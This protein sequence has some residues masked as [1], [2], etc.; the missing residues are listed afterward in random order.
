MVGCAPRMS[1]PH[2]IV[3]LSSQRWD[4]TMWTN[5]QHIMSRLARDHVVLHVDHGLNALPGYVWNQA[6][7]HVSSLAHPVRLLT[8]GVVKRG[9][10]LFTASSFAPLPVQWLAPDNAVRDFASYE[11]KVRRVARFMRRNAWPD[12]IVWVYHP[13]F[14]DALD[15]LPRKLL[16]YDCVDN[17]ASF[18]E[19]QPVAGW[20]NAREERLCRNADLVIT[21]SAPLYEEKRAYNPDHT[22]LVH[23]VGDAEHFAKSRSASTELP[24]DMVGL[25]HPRIGFV[26][27]VSD[28]KLDLEWLQHLA[29]ARP[30][31]QLILIGPVGLSDEST[32]V[33]A[34]R[35]M[36]NVHL[37]GHRAYADLPAYLRA[38][39]V[40]VIPYRI[41]RYTEGV[42]PIKF[43]ELLATGK[44]VV[45]SRL[46]ALA[47]FYDAVRVADDAPGF[48]TA[49]EAALES[50]DEGLDRRLALADQHSWPMRIGRIMGLI[51]ERL[52]GST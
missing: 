4:D 10:S 8:E 49:C 17:Y 39:D 5:K 20:L 26:G 52:D 38:V 30:H 6:R 24:R 9:P 2:H 40:T 32:D 21:T 29:R 35:R 1:S 36:S 28:Y 12:P 27:A 11:E 22:H 34:L 41:N 46:P 42:F 47:E 13:L 37:L 25:P 44:P 18:P 33:R 3:C 43:F 51:Q 23:N 7:R 50:P 15:L 45:I 16:V 19:Y 14:A 31:W 48:V